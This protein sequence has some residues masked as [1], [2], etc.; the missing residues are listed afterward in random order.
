[1][2]FATATLRDTAPRRLCVNKA[3]DKRALLRE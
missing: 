2:K 3:S 1:M